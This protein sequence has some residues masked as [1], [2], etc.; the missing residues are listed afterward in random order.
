MGHCCG[1][2]SRN[3]LVGHSSRTLL[4]DTLGAHTLVGHS[5]GSLLQDTLLGHSC[6]TLLW[7]T[8]TGPHFRRQTFFLANSYCLSLLETTSF[9]QSISCAICSDHRSSLP[10]YMPAFSKGFHCLETTAEKLLNLS[11]SRICLVLCANLCKSNETWHAFK[12]RGST[13][14]GCL[15][16][17]GMTAPVDSAG[18][19][20]CEIHP[21]FTLA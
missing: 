16:C 13:T 10:G 20:C 4:R 5:C 18:N 2:V 11:K 17:P 8:L 7:V 6:R 21:G 12:T 15:R 1:T 14:G 3:N 9:Q 19:V